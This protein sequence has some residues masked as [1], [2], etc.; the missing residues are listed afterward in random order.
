MAYSELVKDFKRIRD[1]LREFFVYGFKSR[2]DYNE[3]SVRGY[4]NERRRIESWLGDFMSFHRDASGKNVFITVDS[5]AIP[6]NPLYKAFKAKTF[7]AID[8]TLHFYV[9]DILTGD[10]KLPLR[11]I[12]ERIT[13]DYL[14]FFD[15]SITLDESTLRKKLK[16]YEN[17]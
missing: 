12:L 13:D 4:D 15:T 7:T 2:A 1:Y 3:K 11:K 6:R 17:L 16:E 8:V 5:R 9:L 14:F 10:I